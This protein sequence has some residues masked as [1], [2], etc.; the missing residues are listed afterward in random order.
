LA[1]EVE[2]KEG[3]VEERNKKD[4]DRCDDKEE[5]KDKKNV[6][7]IQGLVGQRLYEKK[8]EGA[9]VLLRTEKRKDRR[10]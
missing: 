5:N 8:K 4:C 10:R 9:K 2:Q 1:Q 7:R 3:T 6:D